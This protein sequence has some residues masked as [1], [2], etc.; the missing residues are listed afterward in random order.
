ML[1]LPDGRGV[2]VAKTQPGAVDSK[3]LASVQ[4][5]ITQVVPD[6]VG[7]VNVSK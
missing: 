5:N 4:L 2:G 3:A 1:L 6:F 7:K